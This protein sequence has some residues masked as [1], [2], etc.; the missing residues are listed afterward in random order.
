MSAEVWWSYH[1]DWHPDPSLPYVREV[2]VLNVFGAPDTG[3]GPGPCPSLERL[4]LEA[5][6]SRDFTRRRVSAVSVS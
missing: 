3:S 5:Q 4:F 6:E 1:R 2:A